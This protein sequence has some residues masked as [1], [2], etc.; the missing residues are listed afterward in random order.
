MKIFKYSLFL[1]VFGVAL[2]GQAA[3]PALVQD[4]MVASLT[5]SDN[6][7]EE[8]IAGAPDPYFEGYIQA[9]VDMHFYE[10]RVQVVVK[11]HTVWLANLSKNQQNA[12]S[13]ISFIKDVPGVKEVKTFDDGM[14]PK[15]M[16]ERQK[17]LNRPQM[18]GIWFPQMT[19]LFLPLAASPRQVV[20]SI[21]YRGGD[22]VCG[23]SAAVISLGDDFA[24]FRWLDVWKGDLQ[25]GIEGGIWSVFN[26]KPGSPNINGGT[27]LVNTDFY[28]GIP[29]TY[30]RNKWSFR[31]RVYH[32]S[33]HLGDEFMVNHPGFNRV[34]PSY[35]V[36]DFFTSFQASDVWR[37]YIG[38]GWI[39][40]SDRSFP[41][42]R[43]YVQYGVESRFWGHKFYY[44]KLYGNFFAAAHIQNWQVW[45]WNF[46]ETV[47]FGYEWSKLQKVGRKIRIFGEFHNGYSMEGQ[48]FKRKTTYGAFKMSYGF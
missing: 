48:F 5:R 39:M 14:P 34:N 27:E 17:Y 35:E 3:E 26:L 1:C 6:L 19:E 38:P 37:L 33:S 41:M 2:Y 16:K 9:L 20:Y 23:K 30:A 44:H 32:L 13:I 22:R 21:G 15:E 10:Y 43:F 12:Q 40:H 11:D 45:H 8:S 7:P 46:D 18:S 28:G 29:L 4:D 36:L 31:L 24:I 47:V 42:K 25:I